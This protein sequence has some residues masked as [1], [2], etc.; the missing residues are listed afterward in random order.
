MSTS[1]ESC[2]HLDKL[3][4][5]STFRLKD[6][7]TL[8]HLIVNG[9]PKIV[10][11]IDKSKKEEWFR[12]YSKRGDFLWDCST[13]TTGFTPL[14][15]CAIKG[16]TVGMEKLLD[17]GADPKI[18]DR[19]GWTAAEHALVCGREDILKLLKSRGLLHNSQEPYAT[20]ANL[21]SHSLPDPGQVVFAFL[22]PSDRTLKQG[23][24][25][26]FKEMTGAYFTSQFFAT[27]QKLI[28]DHWVQMAYNENTEGWAKFLTEHY[29]KKYLERHPLP[30][31][32][33]AHSC[34]GQNQEK[35]G[36]GVKAK[37]PID[38]GTML[39][40]YLG[41][42]QLNPDHFSSTYVMDSTNAMDYRNLASLLQDAFPCA[43][44]LN[45]PSVDGL[46]G[47][48]ILISGEQIVQDQEITY[49][50]GYGHFQVKRGLHVELRKKEME[51][52]FGQQSLELLFKEICLK[53]QEMNSLDWTRASEAD[54]GQIITYLLAKDRL[55]YVF[56]TYS[57]LAYLMLLGIVSN[58]E[59]DELFKNSDFYEM[60]EAG[61]IYENEMG[62]DIHIMKQVTNKLAEIQKEDPAGAKQMREFVLELIE[63][64]SPRACTKT[65]EQM[66]AMNCEEWKSSQDALFEAARVIH[67]VDQISFNITEGNVLELCKQMLLHLKT[68][69]P[70][71][72]YKDIFADCL[73]FLQARGRSVALASVNKP[74]EG[75]KET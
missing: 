43:I 45:L 68:L 62:K 37:G 18:K 10:E 28:T 54:V 51:E 34:E 55:C 9:N 23:T 56:H 22:D 31:L 53:K 17:V 24:A 63:S 66:L 14:H 19:M 42:Q 71:Y 2:Y 8:H 44:S 35:V 72:N 60:I 36:L 5:A 27:P 75:E 29:R 41:E 3:F 26:L 33:L 4:P 25:A 12:A 46:N 6:P 69:D 1:I 21:L 49:H 38:P 65:L 16:N 70:K 48:P 59:I 20:L 47:V 61:P 30:E 73:V 39:C 32:Y 50:Y 40:P 13:T 58:E 57:S 11:W 52:F 64:V 7:L 74:S 15:L 67:E